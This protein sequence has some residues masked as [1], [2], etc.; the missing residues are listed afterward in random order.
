M[1]SSP[2]STL[3][4][5]WPKACAATLELGA[6]LIS[7]MALSITLNTLAWGEM[8]MVS[9]LAGESVMEPSTA[10]VGSVVAFIDIPGGRPLMLNFAFLADLDRVE[11]LCCRGH[12]GRGRC[13]CVVGGRRVLVA[14]SGSVTLEKLTL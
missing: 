2:I 11:R 5:A 12:E 8:L 13:W 6:A 4:R 14:G 7:A 9:P 10:L 1:R 3:A